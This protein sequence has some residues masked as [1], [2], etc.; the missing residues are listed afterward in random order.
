MG[1]G[2]G[3]VVDGPVSPTS[4]LV[5]K[6]ACLPGSEAIGR[7]GLLVGREQGCRD[8]LKKNK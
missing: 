5:Q 3:G 8:D 4:H 1:F 6:P 7:R 2:K